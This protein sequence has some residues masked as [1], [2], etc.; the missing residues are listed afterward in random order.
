[1]KWPSMIV[2]YSP[3]DTRLTS[4]PLPAYS[5]YP[6]VASPTDYPP[7][8]SMWAAW[9]PLGFRPVSP[10]TVLQTP[11]F[12]SLTSCIFFSC[13]PKRNLFVWFLLLIYLLFWL[14]EMLREAKWYFPGNFYKM[15]LRLLLEMCNFVWGEEH[16]LHDFATFLQF[17]WNW[18]SK[19]VCACVCTSVVIGMIPLKALL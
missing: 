14:I 17:L 13:L 10:A 15:L 16:G 9:G 6:D 8:N 4:W 1:M 3:P 18:E 2:G 12:F 5:Y 7:C 19:C 11:C